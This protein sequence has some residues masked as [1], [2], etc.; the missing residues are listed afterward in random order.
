MTLSRILVG[1]VCVAVAASAMSA[2]LTPIAVNA[3]PNAKALP[4]FA[5]IEKGIFTRHGL[6]LEIKSTDS[7]AEQR[8][9]LAAGDYVL[10]HLAVDNAVA[11]ADVAR[12]DVVIVMGGDSG[13]NELFVQPDVKTVADL[14][15]RALVVDSPDTAY[16][17]QAKKILL[18]SGLRDGADYTV[19]PVGRGELRL[20]AMAQSRDNA[21]AVLNLPY[22]IQARQMGL[23]SLGNTVDMLGP[24][25]AGGAFVMRAWARANA[26][27]LE[28]YL[29]AYIDSLRWVMDTRNRSESVALLVGKLKLTQDVAERTYDLLVDPALGFTPDAKLD[30]EGFRNMLALRAEMEGGRSGTGGAPASPERYLD[31]SYY[32]AAMKRL[33]GTKP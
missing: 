22:S 15:G 30:P 24:Y 17:L 18:R 6:K 20:Q 7:A 9:G 10:M 11:M 31:L 14:R 27:L 25:Q 19:K 16:A 1:L 5:G 8:K 21:A 32:E 33:A 28:R 3:Y 23:R 13:M 4:L 2:E 12:Q 26:A 29:A